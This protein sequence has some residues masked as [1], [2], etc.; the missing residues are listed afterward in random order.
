MAA[1]LETDPELIPSFI[2]KMQEGRWDIVAGSRWLPGGG[3]EGYG[4]VRVLLNRI[5]QRML[6]LL[7]N[8]RLTD[9]TYAYRLYRRETLDEIRWDELGHPFLLECLLKPLR[10]GA[11]VAEVPCRWRRRT[12]GASAG[13]WRQTLRYLPVA[14][15]VRLSPRG[16]IRRLAS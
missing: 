8:T 1:D 15:R 4:M 12:E 2:E 10:L 16:R 6:A 7:Y 14:L 3:F 5:F 11:R 13:S 9:L